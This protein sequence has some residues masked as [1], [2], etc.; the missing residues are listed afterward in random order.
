MTSTF[1]NKMFT[2]LSTSMVHSH[3]DNLFY[4]N[5]LNLFVGVKKQT[6]VDAKGGQHPVWDE[7]LR[8]PIMK[9]SATKYRKL[10]AQ[11]WSK[12]HRDD[13]MLGEGSLDIT[14]TLKTGE[15]DGV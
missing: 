7:E 2:L 15:F 3:V 13:D 12:E 4:F 1:I 14:E 8:F 9:N 10:Q 5:W 6:K 11:C